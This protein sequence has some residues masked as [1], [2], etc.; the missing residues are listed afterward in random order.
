[1]TKIQNSEFWNSGI[2]KGLLIGDDGVGFLEIRL[3]LRRSIGGKMIVYEMEFW[4][5]WEID[6]YDELDLLTFYYNKFLIKE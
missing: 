5:T 3:N 6:T 4:Q 1:M 2:S